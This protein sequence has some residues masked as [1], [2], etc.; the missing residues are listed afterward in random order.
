MAAH[1]ALLAFAYRPVRAVRV[2]AE[3][4]GLT[5]ADRLRILLYHDIPASDERRLEAQLRWLGERWRFATPAQAEAM[6]SGEEPIRGRHL[7]V[8]FDDGYAS[9]RA[10]TERVLDP[11]GIRAL[12]FVVSDFVGMLDDDEIRRFIATRILLLPARRAEELPAGLGNM[13]WSDLEVLLER[14]HVIGAHTRTH[15]LLS[16]LTSDAALEDEIVASADILAE[17]LG[18]SIRHFAYPFGATGNFSARALAI[19]RRRFSFI[20]TGLRGDNAGG[21]LL[22]ALRRDAA[23]QQDASLSYSVMD[24]V[25]IGSFLEGAADV[26]YRP[27]LARYER[28]SRS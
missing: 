7:L 15:A 27:Q 16:D 25:L 17:R 4:V 1:H 19:A 12:F 22:C 24:N 28:W 14:G 13:R 3:R 2:V 23:S 26:R 10:I 21:T 9:N 6:L 8:T 18:V 11:L 20:H 5:R